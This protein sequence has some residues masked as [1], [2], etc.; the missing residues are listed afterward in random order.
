MWTPEKGPENCHLPQAVEL[1]K[2]LAAPPLKAPV[3]HR[4]ALDVVD[5]GV[6]GGKGGG[7]AEGSEHFGLALKG[8]VDVRVYVPVCVCVC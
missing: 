2:A 6:F 7:V 3:S 8:R 5:A 4:R 1:H